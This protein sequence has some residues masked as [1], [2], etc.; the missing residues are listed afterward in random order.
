MSDLMEYIKVQ[1]ADIHHSRNQEWKIL[2]VLGAVFASL[3]AT[4]LDPLVQVAITI[5]GLVVCVMGIYITV[6][7]WM[8]FYSK[9]QFITQCEKALGITAT[10]HRAPF[11]VQGVIVLIY[12]LFASALSGWLGWLIWDS[13]FISSAVAIV[14]L[15]LG[16]CFSIICTSSMRKI[17]D[18]NEQKVLILNSKSKLN[19][20]NN[21]ESD[22][23]R[24]PL[25]VELDD[26]AKCLTLMGQRPLKLVAKKLFEDES[27]WDKPK[28]SFTSSKAKVEDKKLL[29]NLGDEFQ[30]SVASEHSK[31]EF[32]LHKKIFEICISESKMEIEYVY[33]GALKASEIAK[34]ALI[35]P[36]N[37]LHKIQLH[38]LTFVFQCAIKGGMV[39]DDREVV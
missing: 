33:E 18:A 7:H 27:L 21:C 17:L 29:L 16:L 38:G 8:I 39:H 26:L 32:H 13:F 30:F 31:Q 1:W 4:S 34:G 6:A 23:P 9:R 3:L 24:F 10:F 15:V 19:S 5:F 14:V 22:F 25:H 2:A 36:P 12:F 28:W 35:V 11:P 37:V 20:V